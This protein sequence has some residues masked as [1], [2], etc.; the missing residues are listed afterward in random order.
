MIFV[1]DLSPLAPQAAWAY[2]EDGEDAKA[3][4]KAPA[5]GGDEVEDPE[6]AK[7]RQESF[8]A[9]DGPGL[10]I[11]GFLIMLVSFVMWPSS[12]CSRCNCAAIITS[13]QRSTNNSSRNS[14]IR[15]IRGRLKPRKP[16]IL[17]RP[18]ACGGYGP[19]PRTATKPL[20]PVCRS[21]DDE[22]DVNG[23]KDR[24]NR[25]F[26]SVGPML[27]LLGTVQGM[28]MSFQIIATSTTSP[29]PYHWQTVLRPPSSPHWKGRSWPSPR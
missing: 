21:G 7:R 13:P 12:S 19:P 10:G 27:G 5:A 9:C 28:V 29:K 3:D 24:Y 16:A 4:T 8:L 20:K 6:L 17:H 26:G 25:L 15:I 23:T 22:N 1:A 11:F 2:Q 14:T 18:L